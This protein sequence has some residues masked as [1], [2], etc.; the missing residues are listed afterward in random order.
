[1][2][3]VDRVLIKAGPQNQYDEEER[4]ETKKPS[5]TEEE[6]KEFIM[7]NKN[8]IYW[9]GGNLRAGV[10]AA[11]ERRR[12]REKERRE[13]RI[14][15]AEK[16]KERKRERLN[17]LK[18]PIIKLLNEL[19]TKMPASDIDAHLKHQNIDEIKELCE[20]MYHNGEISRT[21]NYRYFILTEEKKKPKPKKASAPKSEAVDVKS[22][23]KKYKEMLDEGLIEQEDY[24]AKKK[25]LLGL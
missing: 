7:G 1:M 14:I 22:E 19:G 13:R 12:T 10:K 9:G 6:N 23:L 17:N 3:I 2:E 18:S 24:D 20:E 21:G 5:T 15:N 8:S 4:K 16:R 25:E 11:N